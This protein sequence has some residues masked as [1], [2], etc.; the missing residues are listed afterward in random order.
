MAGAPSPG[1]DV[2][3]RE[4]YGAGRR[5]AF[6]N[7]PLYCHNTRV[8]SA[9][10]RGD[11]TDSARAE[12]K[13][14]ARSPRRGSPAARANGARLLGGGVARRRQGSEK[15]GGRMRSPRKYGPIPWASLLLVV[16]LVASACGGAD[17]EAP[18]A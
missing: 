13:R 16:A 5:A 2:D 6:T 15:G 9:T 7:G 17:E 18:E 4:G 1:G 3:G 14:G 12:S 8:L 10:Q 11:G